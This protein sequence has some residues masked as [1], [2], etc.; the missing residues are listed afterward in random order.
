MFKPMAISIVLA[1]VGSLLVALTVIPALATYVFRK[2][3]AHRD[4][5]VTRW[6]DRVY[7]RSLHRALM[8]RKSIVGVAVALF[9]CALALVPFLGT[10]FVP[11]LEEGTLGMRVT[12]AP[13][14]NMPTVLHAV[15]EDRSEA[16]GDSGSH[17]RTGPH[18]PSRAGRRSGG[19][20]QSRVVHRGAARRYLE[21]GQEPAGDG[22]TDCREAR[23]HPR[24][25]TFVWPA[26]CHACRRTAV[27]SQSP[28][29]HQALRSGSQGA[30]KKRPSRLPALA[31]RVEGNTRCIAGTDRGPGAAGRPP[32]SRPPG[33]LRHSRGAGH[34]VGVRCHWRQG[35]RPGDPG[36]RA[37]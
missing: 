8:Y 18:W 36:Q 1:M 22:G 12:L 34:V 19:C 13:S 37:V 23:E 26:H 33:A 35:R 27:W 7:R 5:P 28:A 4:N 17:L 15:A 2:E 3:L 32:G 10:E 9:A 14:V 25:G 6:L 16:D 24:H 11:V 30:G 20:L 21:V 31:Q 29:G